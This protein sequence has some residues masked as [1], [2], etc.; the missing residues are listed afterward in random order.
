VI[1][2]VPKTAAFTT[3][4]AYIFTPESRFRQMVFAEM[5]IRICDDSDDISPVVG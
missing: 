1:G 2:V 3:K 5:A 4:S